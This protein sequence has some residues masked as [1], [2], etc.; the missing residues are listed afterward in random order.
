MM[1]EFARQILIVV[2][3]DRHV[4]NVITAHRTRA[5]ADAAIE[6]FKL[7]YED[8]KLT[9]VERDYGRP[10]WVRYVNTDHDDGP[11]AYIESGELED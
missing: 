11:S 7:A 5:G 3:R 9:W 4:D 1:D 10:K 8:D 2:C 6:A